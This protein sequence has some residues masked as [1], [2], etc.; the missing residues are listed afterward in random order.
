MINNITVVWYYFYKENEWKW[1]LVQPVQ[2]QNVWGKTYPKI[3]YTMFSV[4]ISLKV[5]ILKGFLN[6]VLCK[7]KNIYKKIVTRIQSSFMKKLWSLI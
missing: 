1:A 5:T 2:R 6:V 3:V 7:K 4:V